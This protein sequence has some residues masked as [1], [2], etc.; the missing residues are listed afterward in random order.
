MAAELAQLSGSLLTEAAA[1]DKVN[2]TNHSFSE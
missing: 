1:T 2:E